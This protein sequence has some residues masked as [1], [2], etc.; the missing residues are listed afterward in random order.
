MISHMGNLKKT[1]RSELIYKTKRLTEHKLM[2][3]KGGKVERDNYEFGISRYKF[4]VCVCARACAHTHTRELLSW[5]P[6]T[7]A[8]QA[9]LSTEF[10]RQEY[11]SGLPFPP[12][13]TL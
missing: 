8:C 13:G 5:I 12:P 1:D 3:N 11:W 6:W 2:V 7:V 10:S 9:P 4:C